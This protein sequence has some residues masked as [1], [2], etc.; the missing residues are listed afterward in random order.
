M[1]S[2]HLKAG[3]TLS[4]REIQHRATRRTRKTTRRKSSN[5]KKVILT[6]LGFIFGFVFILGIIGTILLLGYIGQIN[7]SLPDP[8][9]LSERRFELSTKIYDR[10]GRLLYTVYG[11]I[12]REFVPLDKFPTYTRWAVLSAEDITFYE[13]KGFDPQSIVGVIMRKVT[14]KQQKLVGASTIDQQL[15]RNTILVD[16]LGQQAF[17][18]SYVRKLKEILIS[19][20][21]DKKLTKDQ[22]LEL[23]LNE[24]P[25]GGVNYGFQAAAKAYFNKNV[26]DLSLAQSAFLAGIIQSPTYYIENLKNGNPEPVLKRRN[27]VLDMMYKYRDKTGVTKEEIEKAKK[28]KVKLTPGKIDIK[29]PH[30][31][32][33]VLEQLEKKYGADMV[34]T[35]GLKVKTTLDLDVQK[36]VEDEVK[37]GIKTWGHKYGAYNGAAVVIDPRTGQVLSMVGSVDYNNTKDPRVD[38]NVNVTTSLRQMGS[39][40]KPYTYITAFERGYIPGTPAPDIK[41]NFGNYKVLDWDKSYKGLLSIAEALNMSRNIPAVYTLQMIG[42]PDAFLSTAKRLGITTLKDRSRYGLSITLGAGEMKLLEHT[43]AYTAFANNGVIHKTEVFL[44]VKDHD[45]KIL[46][47]A[48]PK[49]TEKRVFSSKHVYLLNWI[50][51]MIDG[52]HRKLAPWF[53]SV[54]GQKL[55]GK[56][57]T[58]DGPKDLTAFLY[59]PKLVVGVWS[60][61]NNGKVTK[62]PAGQAWSTNVPLPIANNIMKRLVPKYGKAFYTRPAG[63]VKVSVC[64]DTGLVAGSG[65]DCKKIS[66]PAVSTQIP[67]RDD[68]HI[69]LPICKLNNKVASNEQEAKNAGLIKYVTYFKYTL[70]N[71]LQTKYY[72]KYLKD[73]LGYKLYSE[74][75]ETEVC[76]LDAIPDVSITSPTN[77]STFHRGENI[78]IVASSTPQLASDPISRM[79]VLIDGNEVYATSSNNINYTYTIPADSSLLADGVHTLSVRAV[80]EAG[81]ENSQAITFTVISSVTPTPTPTP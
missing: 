76:P 9:K 32:F 67:R 26:W 36:I 34:K 28:E 80:T 74:K 77:A 40:V 5:T 44:E 49:K 4:S 35:G 56:T 73:K 71:Q 30:F 33:Y 47:K 65:V 42:G 63:V 12:N 39:S 8:G 78:I 23:Y 60:G 6:V 31:V 22:I 38:G 21:L 54:P 55:C 75:P 18:R 46:Y 45:G 11:D 41:M 52:S 62:G 14:G 61:N 70:P 58:T 37:R 20:Q 50:L 57:G 81:L 59:Y 1:S 24:V 17:E 66:S 69:K 29:A 7:A 13:H 64:K 51:C 27:M 19:I 2:L 53:Y 10:K 16:L 48:D 15:V 72:L 3:S 25:L 79:Q 68:A 43:N